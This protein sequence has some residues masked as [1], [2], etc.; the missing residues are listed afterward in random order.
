V[1]FDAWSNPF[2]GVA[3]DDPGAAA[4]GHS[5]PALRGIFASQPFEQK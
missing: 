1:F 2:C 5:F 4:P 3:V